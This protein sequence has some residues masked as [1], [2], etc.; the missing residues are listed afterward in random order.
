VEDAQPVAPQAQAPTA[1]EPTAVE[2]QR[3]LISSAG[4]N[5]P[6][7]GRGFLWVNS[8]PPGADLFWND[9]KMGESPMKMALPV[10][11]QVVTARMTGRADRRVEAN[12]TQ[13]RDE[14]V[15]IDFTKG[16]LRLT[17]N[18]ARAAVYYQGEQL[19]VT[20]ESIEVEPG[21]I[22]VELR[23][24][25]Y[26]DATERFMVRPGQVVSETVTLTPTTQEE[27]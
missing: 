14:R 18:P 20:P 23:R 13:E 16:E 12:I 24:N 22:E 1:P 4:T 17:S 3:D 25:G 7:G 26:E 5:V 19:G 11:E 15:T 9:Q 21:V 6:A 8:D 2:R 10:G 27:R